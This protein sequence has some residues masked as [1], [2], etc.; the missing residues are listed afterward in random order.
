MSNYKATISWQ[1]NGGDLLTGKYSR[2]HI[3]KFDGGLEVPAS[4]SPQIVPFPWSREENVDPEEAFI[5]S[6]SSCH[7]LFY[8][9]LAAEQGFQVD[10]YEDCAVGK[11]ARNRQGKYIVSEVELNPRISHSG[12]LIPDKA[13]KDT[14]H[15]QAN[16][17]C[18][19]ANSVKT[20]VKINL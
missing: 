10:T 7:M 3:W 2:A 15:H 5:A 12:D 8:L 16:D 4:A 17:Q 20:K 14:L 13:A 6:L 1:R 11:M 18:F 9:S 19:I